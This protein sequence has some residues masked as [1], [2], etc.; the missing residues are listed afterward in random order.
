MPA[1]T[2]QTERIRRMKS[3]LQAASRSVCKTCPEE[4]PH[5]GTDQSTRQSRAFGQMVYIKPNALGA[6]ITTPCCTGSN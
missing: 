5:I 3:N 1:D 6:P 2:S 4:G